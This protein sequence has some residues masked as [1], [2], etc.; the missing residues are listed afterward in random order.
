MIFSYT[1]SQRLL[2]S[3]PQS[4]S[5]PFHR[6]SSSLDS[7]RPAPNCI[8]GAGWVSAPPS[9]IT[10]SGATMLCTLF[11]CFTFREVA[12]KPTVTSSPILESSFFSGENGWKTLPPKHHLNARPLYFSIKLSCA[13][14]TQG[15]AH[16]NALMVLKS[17][18]QKKA[19]ILTPYVKK[20]KKKIFYYHFDL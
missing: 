2:R 7:A 9:S 18:Q 3:E 16:N 20:T 10:A 19:S 15:V 6:R 1:C 17:V 5:C 8:E 4:P 13:V 14:C 11:L 12:R